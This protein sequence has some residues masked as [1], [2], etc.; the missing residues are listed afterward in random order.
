MDP[1]SLPVDHRDQ[2]IPCR[3]ACRVGTGALHCQLYLHTI[4]LSDGVLQFYT[5]EEHKFASNDSRP[6]HLGRYQATARTHL[7]NLGKSS[8]ELAKFLGIYSQSIK[9]WR[10]VRKSSGIARDL[11]LALQFR[12]GMTRP[13][14]KTADMD[15]STL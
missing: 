9:T 1:T 14:L 5:L 7:A 11:F 6:S 8:A 12:L 4:F 10:M 13:T 2:S 3:R 15:E